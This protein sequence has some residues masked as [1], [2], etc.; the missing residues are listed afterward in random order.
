MAKEN[1]LVSA[2]MINRRKVVAVL[3]GR[4]GQLVTQKLSLNRFIR[5]FSISPAAVAAPESSSKVHK[6]KAIRLRRKNRQTEKVKN[7]F[8]KMALQLASF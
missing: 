5:I 1:K 8:G 2:E 6:R 3:I 4:K 7:R